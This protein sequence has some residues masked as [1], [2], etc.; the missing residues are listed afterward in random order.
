MS[1][2][3]CACGRPFGFEHTLERATLD[4]EWRR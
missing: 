4:P 1:S 2:G 3:S